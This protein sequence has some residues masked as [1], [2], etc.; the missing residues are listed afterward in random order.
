MEAFS[1]IPEA[2]RVTKGLLSM[3]AKLA[4]DLA[5]AK[6]SNPIAVIVWFMV[7][8]NTNPW[9]FL[10]RKLVDFGT[11]AVT[12][13]TEVPRRPQQNRQFNNYSHKGGPN[14]N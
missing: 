1:E 4:S 5:L 8:L 11:G 7:Q 12:Q 14:R 2:S 13:R 3:I 9:A 6:S 10:D